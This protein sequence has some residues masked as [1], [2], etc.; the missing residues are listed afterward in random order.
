MAAFQSKDRP[1]NIVLLFVALQILCLAGGF[2]LAYSILKNTSHRHLSVVLAPILFPAFLVLFETLCGHSI[3]ASL[4]AVVPLL[5][6][7]LLAAYS[8]VVI[9][10]ERSG[11]AA[12]RWD[13][14]R[15]GGIL[16]A[17]TILG[18]TW[19]GSDI[20][21]G[22]LTFVDLFYNNELL[23]YAALAEHLMG[24]MVHQAYA[25]EY[26]VYSM[27]RS[28]AD[29]LLA[30][31]SYTL[32]APPA[33][34][35]YLLI[36][37]LRAH[38]IA[39]FG[40]LLLRATDGAITKRPALLYS[41]L[42]L[43][44]LFPLELLIL[45]ASFLSQYGV[46]PLVIVAVAFLIREEDITN[47]RVL[48]LLALLYV[49][50][51]VSYP[52]IMPVLAFIQGAQALLLGLRR[53]SPRLFLFAVSP[54]AV[55]F[56]LNPALALERFRF[57]RM[58]AGVQAGGVMFVPPRESIIGYGANILGLR[59]WIYG[60]KAFGNAWTEGAVV[61][62]LSIY[63]A[64]ALYLV[65]RRGN[66]NWA[67]CAALLLIVCTIVLWFTN[68]AK[69]GPGTVYRAEKAIVY[70]HFL[71]IAALV[72]AVAELP[73]RRAWRY[74]VA[75]MYLILFIATFRVGAD[76]IGRFASWRKAY[77]LADVTKAIKTLPAGVPVA[78][79][80]G[81]GIASMY[82][83]GVLQYFGIVE[84][85]VEPQT[86]KQIP[87]LFDARADPGLWPAASRRQTGIIIADKFRTSLEPGGMKT[88]A[89]A[90]S[91]PGKLI[92]GSDSF[93]LCE[94]PLSQSVS[95]FSAVFRVRAHNLGAVKLPLLT[96]GEQFKGSI[97]YL[98]PDTPGHYRLELDVWNKAHKNGVEMTIDP[99][100]A[101]ED[102]VILLEGKGAQDAYAVSAKVNGRT[103]LEYQGV[104]DGAGVQT[105]FWG[106][107]PI[108]FPG[109]AT[110]CDLCGIGE[111][112]LNDQ[113]QQ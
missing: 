28:G 7:V 63:A 79:P 83:N 70:G 93:V 74:T 55:A 91:R 65:F 2:G 64:A 35:V 50:I 106:K 59:F 27:S 54:F 12:I 34:C 85:Y 77:P 69:D 10:R 47:L 76:G 49:C 57:L 110:A 102:D 78:L 20:A 48:G 67:A 98:N 62:V 39:A 113:V 61:I 43:F 11:L 17:A 94:G 51:I 8:A 92:Y 4:P 16:A 73:Q 75:G 9:W 25:G 1:V 101:N 42:V 86:R 58:I 30:S 13:L 6:T 38:A 44:A 45:S 41:G 97:V 22:S 15:A 18:L 24:R 99:A 109:V 40:C 95:D 111:V 29:L 26:A 112:R 23:N 52:E 108:L 103:A 84:R 46:V 90:I 37:L 100:A 88:V 14:L 72:V 21:H 56:L 60:V 3:P 31:L 87:S 33:N 71:F 32:H 96:T 5:I 19:L 68:P 82:W 89:A 53:R 105:M 107:N 104:F 81:N 66:Q 36:S 80:E